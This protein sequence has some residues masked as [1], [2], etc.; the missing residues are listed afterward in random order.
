MVEPE[1]KSGLLN[2]TKSSAKSRNL[3]QPHLLHPPPHHVGTFLHLGA[4]TTVGPDHHA[5]VKKILP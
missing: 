3:H 4:Q 5:E 2:S 1:A